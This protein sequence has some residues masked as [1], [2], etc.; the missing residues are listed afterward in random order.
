MHATRGEPAL[1]RG[2]LPPHGTVSSIPPSRGQPSP[3]WGKRLGR[4]SNVTTPH[5]AWGWS[6]SVMEPRTRLSSA[7]LPQSTMQS[8]GSEHVSPGQWHQGITL[9][10]G[11]G[12]C[13]RQRA[14]DL[15][16]WRRRWGW[17]S[18][19]GFCLL[20]ARRPPRGGA[21]QGLLTCPARFACRL[22]PGWELP[23][24][25]LVCLKITC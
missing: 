25:L 20:G 24:P 5:C 14:P 9:P 15:S 17:S 3:R 18:G 16:V 19:E 13:L 11:D 23:L 12:R 7:D 21:G 22:L 4:V 10:K 6:Y 2:A 1:R 8:K